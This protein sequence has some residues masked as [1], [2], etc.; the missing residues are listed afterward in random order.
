M[1][2]SIYV[3][4]KASMLINHTDALKHCV[5]FMFREKLICRIMQYY[6]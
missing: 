3:T 6:G 2:M 4:K 1:G 5:C